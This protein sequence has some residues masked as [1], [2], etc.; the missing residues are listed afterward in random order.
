MIKYESL[1]KKLLADSEVQ[2]EYKASAL[3]Y[4]VTYALILAR[5]KAKMTQNLENK[6]I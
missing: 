1:R 4:E 2:K 5:I 6:K 3:E